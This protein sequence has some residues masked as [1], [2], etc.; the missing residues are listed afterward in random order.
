MAIPEL[1]MVRV[2]RRLDIFCDR[3]PPH[4]RDQV[5]YRWHVRGN[6]VTVAE[7]RPAWRGSPGEITNHELARFVY[8]PKGNTWMLKWRDRNGRFH[9]YEGFESVRSFDRL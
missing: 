4:A 9:P 7:Q 8:E 2:R 1:E 3:V 5:W 6:Q